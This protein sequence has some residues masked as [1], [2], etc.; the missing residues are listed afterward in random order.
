MNGTDY[1]LT[2]RLIH[3]FAAN[4][5][6]FDI[7]QCFNFPV[8]LAAGNYTAE[9]LLRGL[10]PGEFGGGT[11]ASAAVNANPSIPLIITVTHN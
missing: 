6:E 7:G 3:T 10:L 11:G 8:Q 4:V 1:P 9:L 5:G 2:V